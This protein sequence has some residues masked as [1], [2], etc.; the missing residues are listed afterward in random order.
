MKLPLLSTTATSRFTVLT[1]LRKPGPSGMAPSF[2][3]N[4]EGIL[5]CSASGA[6]VAHLCLCCGEV[7]RRFRCSLCLDRPG[8]IQ[9]RV[10]PSAARAK[11]N[12]KLFHE[13][14]RPLEG[15]Y[16]RRRVLPGR[17][18]SRLVNE[19]VAV[20]VP[21]LHVDLELPPRAIRFPILCTNRVPSRRDSTRS[22]APP[23]H[24]RIG[25]AASGSQVDKPDHHAAQVGDV[26]DAAPVPLKENRKPTAP[27]IMAKYF[28]FIGTMN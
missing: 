17:S 15:D 6:R 26:A 12:S 14:G 19:P 18:F 8:K 4:L 3:P 16:S 10:R 22:G 13:N 5:G 27:K 28:A 2:L 9:A 24:R 7:S 1:S 11:L 23:A 25:A 21:V 20:A